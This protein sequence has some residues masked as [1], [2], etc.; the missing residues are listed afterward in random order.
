MASLRAAH[1]ELEEQASALRAAAEAGA[2]GSRRRPHSARATFE[3][4]RGALEAFLAETRGVFE[5]TR[6]ALAATERDL[7]A[8][9][10]AARRL[11]NASES[12]R[13]DAETENSPPTMCAALAAESAEVEPARARLGVSVGAFE[14]EKAA[15]G[16]STSAA[17]LA[18][19]EAAPSP[20]RTSPRRRR[21]R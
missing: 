17:E 11:T 15:A 8:S 21:W 5:E 12:T 9:Q 13:S 1:E 3:S 18:A 4:E 2:R 7:V 19:A 10:E 16:E 6:G 20:R 14:A